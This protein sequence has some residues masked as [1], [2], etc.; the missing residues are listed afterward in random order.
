MDKGNVAAK[1]LDTAKAAASK[2]GDKISSIKVKIKFG[3]KMNAI[4]KAANRFG[5]A[6]KF[7]KSK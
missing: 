3:D 7:G 1:A 4:K 6:E 5:A 2:N